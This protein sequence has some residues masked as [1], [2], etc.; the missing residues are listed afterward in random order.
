MPEGIETPAVE[1]AGLAPASAPDTPGVASTPEAP[2]APAPAQADA[3]AA[4]ANTDEPQLPE[5]ASPETKSHWAKL[6][7]S[8]DDFKSK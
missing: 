5:S 8:R 1:G 7:E 6:K 4:P 3:P 2:Q